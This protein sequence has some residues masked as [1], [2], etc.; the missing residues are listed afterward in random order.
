MNTNLG[1]KWC[2]TDTQ[3]EPRHYNVAVYR[4]ICLQPLLLAAVTY[5]D[6][7]KRQNTAICLRVL[8][9]HSESLKDRW[10]STNSI[11]CNSRP[12]SKYLRRSLMEMLHSPWKP[13]DPNLGQNLPFCAAPACAIGDLSW[14]ALYVQRWTEQ[15]NKAF[16]RIKSRNYAIFSKTASQNQISYSAGTLGREGS[17]RRRSAI[18]ANMK[19]RLMRSA[20]QLVA[21]IKNIDI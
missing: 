11:F 16:K 12:I 6:H 8:A 1:T 5:L 17:K 20:N 14:P 4:I 15:T 21:M 3:R 2:S 9:P 18:S 10:F 19:L 7:S 13:I